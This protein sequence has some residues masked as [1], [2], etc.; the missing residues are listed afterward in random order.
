V[1]IICPE[2]LIK[3]CRQQA[4]KTGGDLMKAT[5]AR[6]EFLK[7]DAVQGF[8]K[9]IGF[10]PI[11]LKPGKCISRLKVAKHHLQHHGFVHAGVLATMA[12]HTAG[13][14]SYALI[15][16]GRS[17]LTVEYKINFLRPASG[18]FLECRARV[19]KTGKQI[20]ITEAEVYSVKGD[21]ETLVAKAM[22]TMTSVPIDKLSLAT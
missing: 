19:L 5:K 9:Y 12:D 17:I 22:H 1:E 18:E 4:V 3:I 14:A 6:L 8:T 16:E 20:L 10:T 13:Y 2:V 7:K 15:P 21:V 11:S